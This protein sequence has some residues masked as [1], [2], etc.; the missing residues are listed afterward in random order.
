MLAQRLRNLLAQKTRNISRKLQRALEEV[1]EAVANEHRRHHQRHHREAV[2]VPI[3]VGN[4]N[5]GFGNPGRMYGHYRFMVLGIG[6]PQCVRYF[7]GFAAGAAAAAANGAGAGAGGTN[8]TYHRLNHQF[9]SNRWFWKYKVFQHFFNTKSGYHRHGSRILRRLNHHGYMF[10]NFSQAY[11]NSYRSKIYQTTT[12]VKFIYRTI[13][14]NLRERVQAYPRYQFVFQQQQQQQQQQQKQQTQRFNPNIRLNLSLTPKHHQV[15]LK[16][17]KTDSTA[18]IQ[19]RQECNQMNI[20]SYIDFPIGFQFSI[21]NE[22]ILS[23]EILE[24]MMYNIKTFEKKLG[25]LRQDIL[26]L[27]ELGELPIK[28]IADKNVLRVYFPNCDKERLEKL[29]QEK[30]IVGGIIF[31]DVSELEGEEV[32]PAVVATSEVIEETGAPA[33]TASSTMNTVDSGDILSSYYYSPAESGRASSCDNSSSM[34]SVTEFDEDIL[35]SSSGGNYFSPLSDSDI[36]RPQDIMMPENM[37]FRFPEP[38][39]EIETQQQQVANGGVSSFD[40]YDEYYWIS[41]S[42]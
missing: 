40:E 34:S 17:A 9:T 22:T 26:N 42:Y 10:H 37:N 23:D 32:V 30:S 25:E 19:E 4:S 7:S 18:T 14:N 5:R 15:T 21:P 12:N 11:Q 20:G 3:P 2:P 39:Q 6:G 8:W 35:S 13:F 41:A 28:Y 24:E 29:C 31:E 33:M 16:L 1:S 27:F 36:I 38:Q